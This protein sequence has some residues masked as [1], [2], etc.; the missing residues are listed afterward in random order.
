[1]SDYLASQV[2]SKNLT[3]DNTDMKIAK[4]AGI[5]KI[6]KIEKHQCDQCRLAGS[7]VR[8]AGRFQFPDYPI[9]Q[10]PIPYQ[11]N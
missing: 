4:I 6:A 5:A 2:H 10:L 1:L 7:V 11:S 3:G 9:T 8:F